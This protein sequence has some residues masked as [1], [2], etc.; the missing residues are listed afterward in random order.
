MDVE[1][2]ITAIEDVKSAVNA[3]HSLIGIAVLLMIQYS[4]ITSDID[5]R[6]D[7]TI[8][9]CTEQPTAVATQ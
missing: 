7:K 3:K 4:C 5:S 6:A 9:V 1:K 2:I 8:K